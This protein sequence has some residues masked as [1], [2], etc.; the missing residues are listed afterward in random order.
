MKPIDLNLG[1]PMDAR[2]CAALHGYL[3]L[4]LQLFDV[5]D[6]EVTGDGEP[7][8]CRL[9]YVHREGG[10]PTL[11]VQELTFYSPSQRWLELDRKGEA[12]L[13]YAPNV[14]YAADCPMRLLALAPAI[15]HQWRIVASAQG[16]V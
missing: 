11:T 10:V 16:G 3:E 4:H 13:G 14:H 2:R 12:E 15:N 5:V 1:I 8:D 6:Y 7:D 9:W